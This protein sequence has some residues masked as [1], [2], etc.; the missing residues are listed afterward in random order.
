MSEGCL[1]GVLRVFGGYLWDVYVCYVGCLDVSELLFRTS[2]VRKG[3]VKT[4]QVRTGPV[5]IGLLRT[6]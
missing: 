6:G 3:Q 1:K 5:R 2:E 4:G